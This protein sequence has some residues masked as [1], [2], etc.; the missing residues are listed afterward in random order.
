[1]GFRKE[2]FRGNSGGDLTKGE[3]L[4]H[5]SRRERRCPFPEVQVAGG[6]NAG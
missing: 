5:V 1:M 2:G 3:R 4:R 6:V